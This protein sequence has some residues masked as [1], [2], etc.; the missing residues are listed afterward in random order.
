L[1]VS[2]VIPAYNAVATIHRA[3]DG[4]LSQEH[5]DKELVVVDDGSTDGTGELVRRLGVRCITQ[6]NAGP[7][8]A[9]NAGWRASS[10]D[11]VVFTDSDCEPL[12]GWLDALLK[13]FE[14]EGVGAVSGTY[15]IANP[16]GMLPRLIHE[17]IRERHS[18]YGGTVRFFGSY[19]V[20]IR[21]S[22]LEQTGGFDET[23]RRASGEDNDLSYRVLKLGH[24]IAYA[25]DALVAHH[26][27]ER[28]RKYLREQYAHGYWRMKLY[29][30]HPDM[31]G[32][33]DYTKL[34]DVMEP[35]LALLSLAALPVLPILPAT[36][37]MLAVLMFLIQLPAAFKLTLSRRSPVY[38]LLAPVTFLRGYARGIGLLSGFVRFVVRDAG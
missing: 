9:R 22:V 33:D 13:G 14:G 35:P 15:G 26:H 16:E 12:P 37:S 27:T 19:N 20:A 32:G 2:I 8:A 34:K 21:R 24:Q 5:P 36:V 17:E 38:L 18:G 1:K 31:A 23:Y 6:K 25:P 11:V 29:R 30:D 4:A 3:I 7:A 10:G 28:L